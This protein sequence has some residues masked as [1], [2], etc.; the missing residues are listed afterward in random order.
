MESAGKRTTR[1]SDFLVNPVLTPTTVPNKIPTTTSQVGASAYT[2]TTTSNTT[3][4]IEPSVQQMFSHMM[5]AFKKSTEKSE[6]NII[7]ITAA[8]KDTRKEMTELREHIT[9]QNKQCIQ[10][11]QE[12]YFRLTKFED[13]HSHKDHITRQNIMN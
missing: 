1:P 10:I 4:N 9:K 13:D 12:N 7:T 8:V 3:S 2:F 6:E 11:W 5:S